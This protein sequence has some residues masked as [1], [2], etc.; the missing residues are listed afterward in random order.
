MTL[1]HRDFFESLPFVVAGTVRDG[2]PAAR[3]VA[4]R[5]GFIHAPDERTLEVRAAVPVQRGDRVGLLGIE[6]PT[7]RRN[8][9]NGI[10][11]SAG[12][13]GFVLHVEQSFGNCPRY[14]HPRAV[15]FR[16]DALEEPLEGVDPASIARA[17]TFFVATAAPAGVDVSH[18][19]GPPGFVRV[20]GDTLTIPDYRGNR[21]FNTLGNLVVS[22]RAALLF[23][24]FDRGEL[25]HVQGSVSIVWDGPD[26]TKVPGA[27][28]L[29]RVRAERVTRLRRAIDVASTAA[30]VASDLSR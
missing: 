20:E 30:A 6:L 12:A 27:E 11:R 16:P 28:R 1:Q 22:P 25:L 29:W 9:V 24:D 5:P 7:R 2:W 19:G 18:R 4:G 14:I 13:A 26:V 17:D 21:Y 8:R 15:R 10:V 3:I 23:A